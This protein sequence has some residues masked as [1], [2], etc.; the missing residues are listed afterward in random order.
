MVDKKLLE[1]IRKLACHEY[2]E[3]RE[4]AASEM[5]KIN[6]KFF[7]EYYPVWKDWVRDSNPN[8]RRAVEV[9][10][11]R[12]SKKYVKEA[13]ELLEP[14]LYD[15]DKYVRKNCGPF[16]ISHVCHKD[17][18]LAFKKLKEWMKID[19]INVRWNL[20][21]C[22]G[23]WFGL[24]FP[25]ESLKLLKDLAKDERRFVWRATASSLIKILRKYPEYKKEVYSWKNIDHVIEAVKK[26]VEK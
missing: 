24:T 16:A 22:L 26:Y 2:W 3:K 21:M 23:A 15:S 11:L 7:E 13:L 19:D 6:D 20:A 25:E 9:G 4:D 5:K 14:L 17:P 8:I 18:G 12:I 1:K 10:L